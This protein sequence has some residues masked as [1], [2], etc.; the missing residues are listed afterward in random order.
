[1][2]T[3]AL[4]GLAVIAVIVFLF[5]LEPILRAKSDATVLDSAALP[6]VPNPRDT[7]DDEPG[8]EDEVDAATPASD[9]PHESPAIAARRV[10]SDVV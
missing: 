5:V 4:I 10:S 8:L 1:M 6:R 2:T 3:V 7:S 9:P